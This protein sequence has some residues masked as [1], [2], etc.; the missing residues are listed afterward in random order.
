VGI[1]GRN[2]AGK[3][4]LLK[5]LSG[6]TQPSA[7]RYRIDG[8]V[9]A[10]LELGLGFHPDFTGAENAVLGCHLLGV[11]PAEIE[12]LLGDIAAFA[13]VEDHMDQPLRRYST[14][15]QMRLAFA[16]ATAVRPDVLIVDEALSVGDAYFQHKC[17]R[18][19]R[20]FRAAGTTLLLVSHDA[21]AVKSLCDRALLL[22]RGRLVHSGTP[23][24]VLDYYNAL[25]AEQD[26]AAIIQ[27]EVERGRTATRSGGGQAR[28]TAVELTD[29]GGTPTRIFRAGERALLCC[30][31]SFQATLERPTIGLLIRDRLGNDVFGTNT[32]HL[33]ATEP[34]VH[35]GETLT[36]TFQVRL[37]IGYGSYSVTAAVHARET[38]LAESYDWWDH[39]LVFEVIPDDSYRFVGTARL[40]VSVRVAKVE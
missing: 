15:L 23:A 32:L 5:I 13:E 37:D 29:A 19:I 9:A 3:T 27:R 39:A 35:A 8:R 10:L 38:H 20:A 26:A 2:G 11:P 30:T 36:V 21:A 22:D 14:G 18:R 28:L 16:V 6:T 7:G 25:I 17:V 34:V 40:P 33:D 31:V 24:A 1:V 4:T 12:P